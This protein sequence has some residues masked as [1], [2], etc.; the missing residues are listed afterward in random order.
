MFMFGG[1]NVLFFSCFSFPDGMFIS[2]CFFVFV[3]FC[4]ALS[5]PVSFFLF[6]FPC[7]Y[8]SVFLSC[9]WLCFCLSLFCLFVCTCP[10][11]LS[12]CSFS[13]S[14]SPLFVC[15]YMSVSLCFGPVFGLPVFSLCM[16]I[17]LCLF[18]LCACQSV[19]LSLWEEGTEGGRM[20]GEE[21]HDYR[22]GDEA[23][24]KRRWRRRWSH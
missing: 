17:C 4:F 6:L 23:D 10:H 18:C 1:V 13:F 5:P 22:D 20:G 16:F 14:A 19:C 9:V 24:A 11:I 8:I 15:I 21:A 7:L 12:P 2:L 3:R